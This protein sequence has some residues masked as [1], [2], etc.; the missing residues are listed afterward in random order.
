MTNRNVGWAAWD[1]C[2]LGIGILILTWRSGNGDGIGLG[3][4]ENKVVVHP[5]LF[6][7]LFPPD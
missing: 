6:Q 2:F 4:E 3:H 1:F 7:G 5:P